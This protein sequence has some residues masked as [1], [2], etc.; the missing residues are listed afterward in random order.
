[1]SLKTQVFS[2]LFSFLFGVFFS[3]C[4]NLNYKYLFTKKFPIKVLI[5][6]IYIIDFSLLYFLIMMHINQGIIHYYFLL[7][8]G[9]GYIFSFKSINKYVIKLKK[10][11]ISKKRVKSKKNNN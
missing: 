10:K 2:L 11:I 9:I 5:T 1:M 7:F 6:G 3:I 8:I 4:T